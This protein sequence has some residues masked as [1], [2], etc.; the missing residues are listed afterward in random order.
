MKFS[1]WAAVSLGLMGLAALN[2]ARAI[3]VFPVVKEIREETPRDN[4]ITVKSMYQAKDSV[5][6]NDTNKQRYEFVT[7]E[8]FYVPNPGMV[9]NSGSRCWARRI[10][11]W[12]FH[13]LGWWSL[14]AKSVRCALCR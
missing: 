3:E 6:G 14:T 4:Y 11:S 9:K 10:R 12:C 13:R 5:T 8:L 7:L 2:S 1:K